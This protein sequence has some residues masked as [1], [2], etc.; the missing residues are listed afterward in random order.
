[1]KR[2]VGA[3]LVLMPGLSVPAAGGKGQDKPASP[4]E[5]FKALLK[6]RDQLPDELSNAKTPEERN[7]LRERL[8]SLPQRFLELAEKNPNHP[9]ALDSLI[10]T[11]ALVNGTAFPAGGKDTPG[12]RALAIL[13]R[14]HVRIDKLGPVCQHVAFGF[15][16]SHESFLRAVVEQNPHREVQ[17]LACLSLAQF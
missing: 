12:D 6:Q 16:K 2:I 8:S 17:G 13:V 11:V 5:Q 9:V 3:I 14:D 15:H 1:M 4:A 7:K 10:Q